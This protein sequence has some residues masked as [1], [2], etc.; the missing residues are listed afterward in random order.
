MIVALVVGLAAG[1]YARHQ[2]RGSLPVL[3]GERPIGGLAAPVTIARDGFG[4]PTITASSRAD[5]ARALGFLHAQERFFQMDLQRRQAAGELAA[6]FGRRALPADR[7]ARLHRM[8]R[9]A[10]QAV[11]KTTPAYRAVLDAYAAGVNAGLAALDA[12][13]FEYLVLGLR[14]APW[15]PE[16]SMLTVLAMFNTLQGRQAAFEE[17]F[18]AMYD[19]LPGPLYEFLTA[20]GSEWD[21]LVIGDRFPR[22]AVPGADVIDL[23]TRKH[24]ELRNT[25]DHGKPG[26][27][28]NTGHGS[29]EGQGVASVLPCF[30]VSVL[31]CQEVDAEHTAGIGS[32]GW[33]VSGRHTATGA[34]LVAND[35]H[36]AI[37]VPIIWYR[38]VMSVPDPV[39]PG[40][41]LR[42]AGVTLPGLPSLTV[43]S[44]G[45]IAWGF[46][47]SGGDWSDLV[48]I[49][50][51]PRQPGQYMT[52]DGPRGLDEFEETLQVAGGQSE[53][54]RVQWTIWGP[55]IGDDLRGRPLAQRWVAHDPEALASDLTEP[56][57]SRSVDEALVVFAGL[58][59]PAQNLVVGDR[60][61]HIGWTI[62]GPIP[63]RRGHDGARPTS[64]VDGARGWEGYLDS[65][66][67]PRIVDPEVGRIW[68]ANAPVVDGAMLATIGEGG[69]ADGIRARL[70]RDR[71]LAVD[72]VTSAD[73]LA[74]QLDDNALFHDRW[75]QLLLGVLTDDEAIR[76]AP[77]RS[78]FRRLVASTWTGRASIDSAA[79]RLVRTF[80][81]VML[82]EL[83]EMINDLVRDADPDFD[84]GRANRSEGPL[85]QLVNARPPHLL[86]PR[87]RRWDDLMLAAVDRSIADLTG[88]GRDLA[89]A[90]WGAYNRAMVTHP[91]T[92]AL[93]LAGRWLNMP[94]DALAGDIYTPRA[95]SPRAGPSE[96]IVVSPGREGEGIAHMPTGQS[97]HPLSPHYRDQHRAWVDGTPLPFLPGE[98][99]HTLV[100]VPA[101]RPQ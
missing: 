46:T 101:D 9:V 55:V 7:A 99:A 28:G 16:D 85:W 66:S 69:Y 27:H 59:I 53:T 26:T 51:D 82:R 61:G 91:L 54:L 41:M 76:G 8:R 97:G 2:L 56:E 32:N 17:T 39:S 86:N 14:P 60:D 21:A 35:M 72:R 5:A 12:P 84:F 64:W 50:A 83:T 62:A 22:P 93:P 31:L 90:T 87:Y 3:D 6:L 44:N 78:E 29:T 52:P 88:E 25:E 89:E 96:R 49:E 63:R 73:M 24:G 19:V 100:L 95:H 47:N 48:V 79:Y 81:Q 65:A 92:A 58:G 77:G 68:T 67:Q 37:N 33:V 94:T 80:R 98:T 71:L 10:Q 18:G 11:A 36:L 75:R 74:V 30:S 15:L 40:S 20:R 1:V 38:A 43:G 4:I 57:R 23:R 13:P 34:A 70:I 42:L 45:H